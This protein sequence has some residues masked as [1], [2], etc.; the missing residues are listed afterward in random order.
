[1]TIHWA[2]HLGWDSES[3]LILIASQSI[4]F[5]YVLTSFLYEGIYLLAFIKSGTFPTQYF[6]QMCYLLIRCLQAFFHLMKRQPVKE[7]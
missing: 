4:H 5:C 3:I 1:M 2:S 6:C 7:Y